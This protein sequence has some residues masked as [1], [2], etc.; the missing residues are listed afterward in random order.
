MF[1]RF[2]DNKCL[3]KIVGN[4]LTMLSSSKPQS[5][6]FEISTECSRTSGKM[7]FENRTKIIK[8]TAFTLSS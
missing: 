7:K 5:N 8:A 2:N 6:L 4:S 1:Q 3:K